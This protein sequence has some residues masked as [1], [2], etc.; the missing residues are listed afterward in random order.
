MNWRIG[1]FPTWIILSAIWVTACGVYGYDQFKRSTFSVTGSDGLKFDVRAP[2][3]TAQSDVV[4]FVQ[5]SEV[6][7]VH[8]EN[9]TMR[10]GAVCQ[11]PLPLSMPNTIEF[12][13]LLATAGAGPLGSLLVG[14]LGF[15]LAAGFGKPRQP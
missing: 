13:P 5:S 7:K 11:F 12:W 6:A 9:C 15:W 10:P 8:R 1:F 3:N 2:A 4:A 14:L